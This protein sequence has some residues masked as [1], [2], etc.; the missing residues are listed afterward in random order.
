[1]SNTKLVVFL[2]EPEE[3]VIKQ[4]SKVSTDD[5]CNQLQIDTEDDLHAF[6]NFL[7]EEEGKFRVE[8]KKTYFKSRL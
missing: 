7:D 5:V 8:N 2:G 1:M 3:F 6:F 4:L